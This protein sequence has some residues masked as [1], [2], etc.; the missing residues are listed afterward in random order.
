VTFSGSSRL[1]RQ[2]G[3]SRSTVRAAGRFALWV[4][5]G[6]V[7][8]R[9]VGAILSDPAGRA[10]GHGGEVVAAFP[11]DEA[12]AFAVRFV[13]AYLGPSPGAQVAPFL[14]DDL[15]SRGAVVPARDQGAEVVGAAVAR[16]A[17]LGGAR[18]LVTVAAVRR[19]GS[20]RYVTVPVAR[21]RRGGLIVSALPSFSPP[22]ARATLDDENVETLTGPGAGPIGELA[23]VPEEVVHP[24]LLGGWLVSKPPVPRR[25]PDEVA[26]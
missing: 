18:A 13:G 14:A 6:I 21:D 5:V 12:R 16:V 24:G 9:G 22:P 25:T 19:D 10:T 7:L 26:R 1:A 17:S 20:S 15:R 8:V 4:A 11:D 23:V 3:G 2:A